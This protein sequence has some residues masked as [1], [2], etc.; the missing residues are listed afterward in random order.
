MKLLDY[1]K[2]NGLDDAAF[3]DLVGG[4]A[5]PLAVRKWKYR[6]TNPRIPELARI[7]E[8]TRGDVRVRD[9]LPEKAEP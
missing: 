3:A 8:V 7:E 1:M 6:E 4:G 2:L 5:T 9:F